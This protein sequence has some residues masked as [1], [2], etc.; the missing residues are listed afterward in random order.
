MAKK[1][2]AQLESS[3]KVREAL[4]AFLAT[5]DNA[6]GNVPNELGMR[7]IDGRVWG[8]TVELVAS[9]RALTRECLNKLPA[10]L[11]S[12]ED[13]DTAMWAAA[14]HEGSNKERE[15]RFFNQIETTTTVP[16][17]FFAP[18]FLVRLVKPVDRLKIG[19]AEIVEREAARSEAQRH[20]FDVRPGNRDG[21]QFADGRPYL[22]FPDT[23]WKVS[24]LSSSRHV[25]EEA[26]W[27]INIAISLL[28]L[29]LLDRGQQKA[30][31]PWVGRIE[32]HPLELRSIHYV[33]FIL[34]G[35][36]ASFGGFSAR[37]SYEV[38]A[39]YS[40]RPRQRAL[41]ICR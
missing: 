9:Q 10:S 7:M 16:K 32:A 36:K 23:A 5:A 20:H 8:Y 29:A 35:G 22:E 6:R 3:E 19:G 38:A 18:N 2:K 41:N 37:H 28:R 30:L 1:A 14:A 27:P 4:T 17:V 26:E 13:L 31:F 21:L 34:D 40:S 39:L 24:V 11:T 12:E 25:R 33:G 15:E